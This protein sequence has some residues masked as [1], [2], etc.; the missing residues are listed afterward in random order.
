[1]VVSGMAVPVIM[2]VIVAV[3]MVMAV[4]MV[5]RVPWF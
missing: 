3:S 2:C 5:V 1:M 4:F